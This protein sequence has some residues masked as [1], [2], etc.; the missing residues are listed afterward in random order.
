MS[1]AVALVLSHVARAEDP[2]P[3]TIGGY[4]LRFSRAAT[5]EDPE[6]RLTISRN[7][8]EVLHFQEIAV[9]IDHWFE[10]PKDQPFPP[11]GTNVTGGNTP[12]IIVQTFTMGAHCC[13]KVYVVDLAE[14][15]TVHEVPI[16][17]NYFSYFR[18][19]GD[20]PWEA[21]GYDNVFAYWR[22]S[23]AASPA[24]QVIF[25]FAGG[26]FSLAAERMKKA[27]PRDDDLA[28]EAMAIRASETDNR[29]ESGAPYELWYRAIDLIYS[30]NMTAA[31]RFFD[32]AWADR[33]GKDAAWT[34]LQCQLRKSDYWPA[35]AA[36][37]GTAAD[38][39]AGTCG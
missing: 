34:N 19:A 35:L 4:E 27:A 38:A 26:R 9:V 21:V 18:R 10:A 7:Q 5:P 32:L 25:R 11:P 8:H 3:L 17:G 24:P 30:G 14:T 23:F 37:N 2:K 15:V 39:P 1:V 29:D 12:Q 6:Q 28:S 33:A 36:M 16:G 13:L 22:G 20:G 31:K